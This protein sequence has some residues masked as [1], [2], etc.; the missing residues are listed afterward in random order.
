[1]CQA[2]VLKGTDGTGLWGD[3]GR[4]FSFSLFM[5][6]QTDPCHCFSDDTGRRLAGWDLMDSVLGVQ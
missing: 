2:L 6:S 3:E 4:I 1:M 5:A